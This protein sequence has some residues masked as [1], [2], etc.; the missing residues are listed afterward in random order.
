MLSESGFVSVTEAVAFG[1]IKDDSLTGKL[2]GLFGAGGSSSG[3][4]KT[5]SA[6]NVPPRD[7][8]AT[9]SSESASAS[10]VPDKKEKNEPVENTIALTV[11]VRF[12][13][14]PPMTEGEKKKSRS[15]LR[16]VDQEEAAK[17]RREEARNTF[18]GYLYRLRDL[19]NEE[20]PEAPFK[21]CSKDEERQSISEKLDESFQWLYDRGDLAE[22]SQFLDKRI[23]LETLERPIIHRYQEIEAFPQ[24][25]NNSQKWNWS[26]RLFLTEAHAN[27]TAEIEADLPSKWTKEELDSLEKTL[28]EHEAWLSE[29][30]EK[31]KSVKF[32]ED[33]VI[34]TTEMKA[35]AKVLEGQLHRLWKRKVPKAPK[36]LKVTPTTAAEE[37]QKT[38][39]DISQES[40]EPIDD[41]SQNVPPEPEPTSN[42][43]KVKPHDEL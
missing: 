6:E 41:E 18:E 21:K 43:E 40:K 35:R 14:I 10:A 7:A 34:E 3:D 39:D 5:E 2:K 16:A 23:A 8:D 4:I 30:V 32:N 9:S 11:D 25:L 15:R 28:K 20:N 22:T 29:W 13:T 31:Q 24:A 26:T 27:L 12:T 1:E 17:S 37:P 36:K 33:P 42:G 19:L 38:G